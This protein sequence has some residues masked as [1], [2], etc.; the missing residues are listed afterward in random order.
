MPFHFCADEF[1]LLLM[2]L[3]S[4]SGIRIIW[5]RLK[6]WVRREKPHTDCPTCICNEDPEEEETNDDEHDEQH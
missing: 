6:A 5:R 3:S 2:M 1:M 4:L